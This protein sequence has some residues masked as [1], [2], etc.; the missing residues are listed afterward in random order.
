MIDIHTHILP[1]LDDGSSSPEE[2]IAMLVEMKKQGLDTVVATPHFYAHRNYPEKFINAR[3]KAG[4]RL[5]KALIQWNQTLDLQIAL[6]SEVAFFNDISHCEELESMCMVGTKVLLLEMPFTKITPT[7]IHE[8]EEI[9]RRGITPIVAHCE[10][11]IPF[12]NH[13]ELF[14]ELKNVGAYIQAN[15]S[16]FLK[17]KTKRRALHLLD[18]GKIHLLGSDAHNMDQR[19]PCLGM[20]HEII[21][22]KLGEAPLKRIRYYEK[23]LTQGMKVLKV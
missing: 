8:V 1:N 5:K 19:P 11:Y 20:V 23:S 14:D 6:G 12:K 13:W 15:G 16:F 3:K 18:E 10:R 21:R 17:N 9:R 4:I 22:S 7:M 2:S